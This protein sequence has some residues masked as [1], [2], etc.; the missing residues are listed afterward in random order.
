MKVNR[1]QLF[2]NAWKC[3]KKWGVSLSKALKM[4]W[5]M[6]KKE[7]QIRAYYGISE[8]YDFEFKLWQNYGKTRAYYTTNGMSNHWNNSKINYVELSN[9]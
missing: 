5:A 2:K 9:I 8:C 3:I 7:A 1:S 6:A 4:A